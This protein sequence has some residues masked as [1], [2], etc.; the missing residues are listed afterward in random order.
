[1]KRLCS[2]QSASGS[3]ASSFADWAADLVRREAERERERDTDN[4]RRDA[5][6]EA[7]ERAA[8]A[9]R[10]MRAEV[11][12]AE[13]AAK[14]A[15]RAAERAIPNTGSASRSAGERPRPSEPPKLN[16][17]RQ[18]ARWRIASRARVPGGMTSAT[19]LAECAPSKSCAIE[20]DV[21]PIAVSAMFG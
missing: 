4:K 14:A 10:V 17:L 20:T 18:N 2:G 6:R 16:G 7:Y 3:D 12:A 9:E 1:M 5:E 13:K 19:R 8:E 15:A 21:P 11:Y